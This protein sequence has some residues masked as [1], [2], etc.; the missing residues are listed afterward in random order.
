MSDGPLGDD[1]ISISLWNVLSLKPSLST[2][3]DDSYLWKWKDFASFKSPDK[4]GWK[5][6]RGFDH[7]LE[8]PSGES[9]VHIKVLSVLWGNR[10]PIPDGSLPLLDA[11]RI[12]AAQVYVS[13]AQLKLVLASHPLQRKHNTLSFNSIKDAKKL[14]EA[15]E[16]RFGGNAATKKTQRNLLK[17]QYENFTAPSSRCVRSNFS[18]QAS[19][20]LAIHIWIF[21]ADQGVIDSE[22]L[23]G[24]ARKETEL[25]LKDYILLPLRVTLLQYYHI[26]PDPKIFPHMMIGS[27]PSSG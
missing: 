17:Q 2:L 8:I 10:L 19:L 24:Q 22:M 11:V 6:R 15:V 9:K 5:G 27:K 23:N 21:T 26:F 1:S 7:F 16:K 18:M 20:N 14:L 3:N 4:T 12:T 13:A 25:L